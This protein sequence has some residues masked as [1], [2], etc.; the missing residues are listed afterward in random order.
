[1]S[2]SDPTP[3]EPERQEEVPTTIVSN[4]VASPT[5]NSESSYDALPF[6]ARIS[7]P[8]GVPAEP[9]VEPEQEVKTESASEVKTEVV[10]EPVVEPKEEQS[11]WDLQKKRRS[12][13]PSVAPF[14]EADSKKLYGG[15]LMMHKW[16]NPLDQGPA[17]SKS[18]DSKDPVK[19]TLPFG[20]VCL[21]LV[22]SLKQAQAAPAAA[23]PA[24][25]QTWYIFSTA[26]E[27]AAAR[28]RIHS[29]L[30]RFLLPADLVFVATMYFQTI[31]TPVEAE[32]YMGMTDDLAFTTTLLGV[33]LGFLAMWQK[34]ARLLTIF[35][36]VFIVD[37]LVNLVRL[38]T[39]FQF[40]QFALQLLICYVGGQFQAILGSSWFPSSYTRE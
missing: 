16:Y 2:D 30:L 8:F 11:Y 7:E 6:V 24:S 32:P 18:D 10:W 33:I 14:S 29:C 37:S 9:S 5:T 36:C 38:T 1:M 13:T 26:G 28:A 20:K 31:Y 39:I 27:D 17:I 25:T 15:P 40:V 3:A 12:L 35:I 34:D 23:A 19:V 22:P 21:G 4:D